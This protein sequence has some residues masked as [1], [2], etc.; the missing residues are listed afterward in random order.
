MV[1]VKT[2]RRNSS[3]DEGTIRDAISALEASID[4]LRSLIEAEDPEDGEDEV[5]A[6]TAV[7]EPEQS[8]PRKDA[9]LA[10]I[11]NLDMEV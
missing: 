1:S 11:K 2:G 4:A 9:L 8:N 6:N 7:E 3:K 5:K 10:T